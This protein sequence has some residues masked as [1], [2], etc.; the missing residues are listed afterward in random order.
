MNLETERVL[1]ARAAAHLAGGTT[2]M[3]ERC[4]RVGAEQYTSAAQLER[5][6]RVLF[7]EQP[8]IA[9]LS[10]DLPEPGTYVTHEAGE[11]PLVL[12][13]AEN[14]VVHA[15]INACRHRGTRV[16]EGRGERKR[17]TC[18]FHAWTYDLEGR[19]CSRPMSCGGFDGIGDEFDRLAEVPCREVA[20]M[21]FVL[22]E[23]SDI[24]R[25]VA[26]LAGA[27]RDEIGGYD[28]PSL[29]YF[30]SRATERRCNY[31]FIMDGFGES[32][33]LKVLHKGTIAPYYEAAGLTD[34]LGPVVR[35]VGVRSSIAR[36]L[37]KDPAEQ[38]FLRH[39]T[40][41]Y[42]IPPNALLSHQVDHVQF[43]QIY[44]VGRDPGRCRVE[45]R[46]YWP[47]PIDEEGRR[48]AEFNLDVL[49]KVTTTEDFP[50]S[51]RI[52]ANLA[53]GAIRELVFG[54][55][56]P[57]LIHYHKQIARAVGGEAIDDIVDT[58]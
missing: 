14:G 7:R 29:G 17:L 27:M 37:A 2:D 3:A 20:G 38:R 30:G 25:K 40:I 9:A 52:H 16:A 19:V 47:A 8:L 32:Y 33:H 10:P 39:G 22:L 58:R 41:Q 35:H 6:I 28:I 24:D 53:S 49:W 44:P 48:K 11:T 57:A 42:M 46:L 18:P 43:W 34:P 1:L 56:E 4:L 23:G 51:D 15:F 5:E 45:L 31:K 50:Q 12:T 26:E 13:R 21:I 54:R 55:N 36:E